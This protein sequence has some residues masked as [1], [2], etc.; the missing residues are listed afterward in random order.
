MKHARRFKRPFKLI[1]L[2]CLGAV[3]LSHPSAQVAGLPVLTASESAGHKSSLSIHSH[4]VV[5]NQD[6]A[7]PAYFAQS[8]RSLRNPSVNSGLPSPVHGTVD[9]QTTA[10]MATTDTTKLTTE[11]DR[12][13][14]FLSTD[15]L[16]LVE[17]DMILFASGNNAAGMTIDVK[18]G[19]DNTYQPIDGF[20]ASLTDTSAWLLWEF[21]DT[22]QRTKLLHDLFD[23]DDG[24]GLSIVRLPMGASDY[25]TGTAYTYDDNDGNP[26]SELKNFSIAHDERYIIPILQEI[27]TINPDV[28][29]IAAPWTAPAWMK[30]K[31]KQKLEGGQLDTEYYGSYA[32]YFRKFIEAYTAHGLPIYAISIQNEPHYPAPLE[33]ATYPA[34]RFAAADA[35]RF[36]K[37]HLGPD[38]AENGIRTQIWIWDHNWHESTY[39][40]EVLAD[41]G[42]RSYVQGV[43][44]HCYDS[45]RGDSSHQSIVKNAYPHISIHLTE[46]TDHGTDSYSKK[47]NWMAKYLLIGAMRNSAQSVLRWNLALDTEHGPSHGECS[48]CLGMVT[49]D[50]E[51]RRY[52]FEDDFYTLGHLSRFVKP[53]ALR[54]YSSHFTGTLETVA[55]KNRD[56]SMVLLAHNAAGE[57]V[58]F[59]VAEAGRSFKYELPGGAAATFVWQGERTEFFGHVAGH[60]VDT[61]QQPLADVRVEIATGGIVVTATST[62]ASGYYSVA[63]LPADVYTVQPY[64]GGR[65]FDPP[66]RKFSIP[67]N[68]IAADFAETDRFSISGQVFNPY[69]LPI[70]DAKIVIVRDGF[71][72]SET[73]TADDGSYFVGGLQA[74]RYTVMPEE[75]EHEFVPISQT[76]ELPPSVLGVNFRT[77]DSDIAWVADLEAPI[78][79][80]RIAADDK[81][82]FA[83]ADQMLYVLSLADRMHPEVVTALLI[84]DLDLVMD[85]DVY[86]DTV[87]ITTMSSLVSVDVSR[88]PGGIRVSDRVVRLRT[89]S[90]YLDFEVTGVDGR[91]VGFL[92]DSGNTEFYGDVRLSTGV[93]W[94]LNLSEP[95]DMKLIQRVE[96]GYWPSSLQAHDGNLYVGYTMGKHGTQAGFGRIRFEDI[97]SAFFHDFFYPL[98]QSVQGIVVQ[99]HTVFLG[100][101]YFG[102][103][104][105]RVFDVADPSNIQ[106]LGFL[107]SGQIA[108]IALVGKTLFANNFP[109]LRA[110]DIH[111][112]SRP[113]ER[114]D[115]PG[116]NGD[117]AV[118]DEYLY[119]G[120]QGIAVFKADPTVPTS[121]AD[122]IAGLQVGFINADPLNF[123]AFPSTDASILGQLS[124]GTQVSVLGQS[125]DDEWLHIRLT[126]GSEGWVSAA[127]VD[128]RDGSLG[129]SPDAGATASTITL[130]EPCAFAVDP[131]LAPQWK[132]EGLGCASAPPHYTWAAWQSF[133]HGAMLWR[134]DNGL[135][136]TLADGSW[137]STSDNWQ[138][139]ETA[140]PYGAPP[141]GR[142]APERG[143]GFVWTR[144]APVFSQLGWATDTERGT[145]MVV[146]PFRTGEL[147]RSVGYGCDNGLYSHG[148]EPNFTLQFLT[149]YSAYSYTR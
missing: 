121:T 143:I 57:Q 106:E 79:F 129:Y 14:V 98:K 101:L 116:I 142:F 126:N 50:R 149:L 11:Q 47:L 37:E 92:A 51:A 135:I 12:V 18:D 125:D 114:A 9:K 35:I 19:V 141:N 10:D 115:F 93:I 36:I 140:S 99:G 131:N 72:I 139:E 16:K 20:G 38:F 82:L 133:E 70:I 134:E 24:L 21:L 113:V 119:V 26:D 22:D 48:N 74:G 87:Y 147:L 69:N 97:G 15:E 17:Q 81:H 41:E 83:V 100:S 8:V 1:F 33:S 108:G 130:E 91:V 55:F 25:Y 90:F 66:S 5:R 64:L 124:T 118:V 40:L 58:E 39:P 52:D 137:Q 3:L 29:I 112:P 27:Q 127:Y 110:Y 85:V 42:A 13:R 68:S 128:I 6:T 4:T 34:M 95:G 145:C 122:P 44:F 76:F 89:D 67:P 88:L 138:G 123:R 23:P 28:K 111:D 2:F 104:G 62:D 31:P 63:G 54:V 32:V 96:T 148:Q 146:Q 49:I 73:V 132:Q 102:N 60:V 103:G 53:G 107:D 59:N 136:Y 77:T 105:L 84:P 45:E 75:M 144:N 71:V 109:V 80:S 65:Y 120:G 61:A 46:C 30:P 43:A 7:L 86:D 94:V 78:R 56:G 117:I